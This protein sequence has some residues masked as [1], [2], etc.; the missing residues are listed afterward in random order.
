MGTIIILDLEASIL[1]VSARSL[2]ASPA[3]YYMC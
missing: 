1:K 2:E 3:A